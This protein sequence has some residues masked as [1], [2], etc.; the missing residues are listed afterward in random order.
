MVVWG[1]LLTACEIRKKTYT[2][3]TQPE[4]EKQQRSDR[5][6]K[7]MV[8]E[9]MSCA[10]CKMRVEKAL[11]AIRGV[12]AQVDLEKKTASLVLSEAVDDE[13][14]KRPSRTPVYGRLYPVTSN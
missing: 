11:N 6:E 2:R 4:R 12:S 5:D 8:I 3:Q 14:L 1:K 9:G 13:T 7:T 10:H